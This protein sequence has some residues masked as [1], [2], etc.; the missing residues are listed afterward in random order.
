ML[1]LFF[2]SKFQLLVPKILM[3]SGNYVK[4][5]IYMTPAFV[6]NIGS[7]L[8]KNMAKLAFAQDSEKYQFYME[9]R[10]FCGLGQRLQAKRTYTLITLSF[11]VSGTIWSQKLI[12]TKPKDRRLQLIQYCSAK[13]KSSFALNSLLRE[14]LRKPQLLEK[15]S[16]N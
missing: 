5:Y 14:K 6:P 15:I 13:R 11:D 9:T 16:G 1:F 7:I 4:K 3:F 12:I 8:P 10:F 2:L